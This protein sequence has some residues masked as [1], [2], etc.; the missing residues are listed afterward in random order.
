MAK[1]KTPAVKQQRQGGHLRK[2]SMP[3]AWFTLRSKA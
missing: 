2:R 3:T 1:Q